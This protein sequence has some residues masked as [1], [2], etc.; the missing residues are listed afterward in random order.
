MLPQSHLQ[1]S[2]IQFAFNGIYEF[3]SDGTH[4]RVWARIGPE[5]KDELLFT[6]SDFGLNDVTSFWTDIT[7][8]T[9]DPQRSILLDSATHPRA[10]VPKGLFIN[11]RA[12]II[13][14]DRRN[15][16]ANT[17]SNI[18]TLSAYDSGKVATALRKHVTNT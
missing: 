6:V 14:T 18:T 15:E 1:E 10:A 2:G 7:L 12:P 4:C 5:T 17:A 11:F 13:T 3:L 9:Y 16:L 8:P